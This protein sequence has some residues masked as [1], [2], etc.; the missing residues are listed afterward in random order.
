MSELKSEQA[1]LCPSWCGVAGDQPDLHAHVSTDIVGGDPAKPLL[2]RMIQLA[3]SDQTRVMVGQNVVSIDEAEAFARA[4]LRL[5]SAAQLAEPG[6]GFVEVLA[7]QSG[8][9]TTEMAL[10][11]GLDA[12]RVR[13]Q[14][15]G[16]RVLDV[17]EFDRL[18][19]AV[20]QLLPLRR[21]AGA[22]AEKPV[23]TAEHE[24]PRHESR[25]QAQPEASPDAGPETG[26]ELDT[27]GF[28]VTEREVVAFETTESG[29]TES[30]LAQLA[31]VADLA[32]LGRLTDHRD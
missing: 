7:A 22:K 25:H 19:L 26:P 31:G 4:L 10:A 6:L 20:A 12:E 30:S 9:S 14:R 1:G 23:G 21:H 3:G 13:A 17:R 27:V 5:T 32:E 2:A 8:V 15:A 11:A 16:A 29:H 24:T 28:E 18:A